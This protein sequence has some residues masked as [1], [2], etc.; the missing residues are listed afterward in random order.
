VCQCATPVCVQHYWDC[1]R[2][3]APNCAT[4]H[5]DEDHAAWL[6]PAEPALTDPAPRMRQAFVLGFSISLAACNFGKKAEQTDRA[7]PAPE[8][9]SAIAPSLPAA[10]P[11]AAPNRPATAAPTAQQ[12]AGTAGTPTATPTTNKPSATP[13]ATPSASST[14]PAP[15]PTP[16]VTLP[17]VDGGLSIPTAACIQKCQGRLQA[18]MSKPVALDGGLPTLDSLSECKK[19]FEDCRTDCQ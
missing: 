9:S 16:A 18:C 15:S 12:P 7:L 6:L 10:T 11:Q 2:K 5:S 13:S 4:R 8:P 17:Q 3:P 19:A 14:A 1:Y